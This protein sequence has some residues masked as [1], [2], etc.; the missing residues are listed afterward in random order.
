MSEYKFVFKITNEN[1]AKMELSG[2]IS[3]SAKDAILTILMTA[4][5]DLIW[6]SV[7]VEEIKKLQALRKLVEKKNHE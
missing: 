5:P 2:T 7:R 4:D 1:K 3:E 6:A